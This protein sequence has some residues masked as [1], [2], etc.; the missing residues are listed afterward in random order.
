MKIVY[1]DHE[2]VKLDMPYVSGFL[3]FREAAHLLKLFDRLFLKAPE[4]KP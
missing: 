1:E 4:F 3:A 2:F